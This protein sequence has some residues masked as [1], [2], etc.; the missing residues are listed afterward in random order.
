VLTSEPQET[1][2]YG[3]IQRTDGKINSSRMYCILEVPKYNYKC[4]QLPNIM[5]FGYLPEKKRKKNDY[6]FFLLIVRKQ[7]VFKYVH[8]NMPN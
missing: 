4:F 3:H 1:L 6:G 5:L 8:I 2:P 7:H